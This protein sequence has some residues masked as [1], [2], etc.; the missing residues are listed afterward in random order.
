MN[1]KTDKEAG[2]L[3]VI[4]GWLSNKKYRW[5]IIAVLCLLELGLLI[6]MA[7]VV[8]K[9]VELP[10]R[11]P[12]V[13]SSSEIAETPSPPS[14]TSPPSPCQQPVL[15]IGSTS[16]PVQSIQHSATGSAAGSIALPADVTDKAFWVYGTTTRYVF[17]LNPAPAAQALQSRLKPGDKLR[18]VWADCSMSDFVVKA[19]IPGLLDS[20]ALLDQS[21]PGIRVFVPNSPSAAG[22]LI[23]GVDPLAVVAP[24]A[25]CDV[26]VLAVGARTYPIQP[27]EPAAGG[28]FAAPAGEAD[29]AYWYQGAEANYV[30]SLIPSPEN[31][32]IGKTLLPGDL[33]SITDTHCN[34]TS[35][36]LLA[37][38]PGVTY[39]P[40]LSEQPADGVILFIQNAP[41]GEG[42]IVRGGPVTEQVIPTATPA[43][44]GPGVEAEISLLDTSTSADQATIRVRVSIY[45]YGASAFTVSAKDVLLNPLD[46][47]PFAAS[48]ADPALPQTIDPGAT[49]VFSF[50]FPRPSSPTA[51][52][53]IFTVEYDLEGY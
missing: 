4:A 1:Q 37:P 50:T 3:P 12:T 25:A 10:V 7:V 45:N 29:A 48:S 49:Q 36:T 5:W 8:L 18:I 13:V 6:G 41:A 27:V 22:F 28:T 2:L 24:T 33:L 44:E 43:P 42:F 34:V 23:E 14:P 38:E 26:P 31:L 9:M 39:A 11:N 53:K 40:T 16:F 52:I 47:G 17:G 15:T 30:F 46:V 51:V 35:Y 19:V 32:A 21:T 20:A